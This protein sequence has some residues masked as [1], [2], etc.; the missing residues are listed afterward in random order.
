MEIATL[1]RRQHGVIARAQALV[2]LTPEQVRWRLDSGAWVR[3]HPGVYRSAPVT[4]TWRGRAQ[5]A[6]LYYGPG[7]ALGLE[8]AAYLWG[9]NDVEPAM[10]HVDLPHGSQHVRRPGIR[11]RRRRRLATVNRRGFL[12]AAAAHCVIDLGDAPAAD[13]DDAI[14]VAARAVQ[15]RVV[16]V[17]EL[18]GE[19]AARRT[20]RHRRALELAL[21]VVAQGAESGLEVAFHLGVLRAHGLPPME[22]AVP[23]TAGGGGI[24]RDFLDRD[25]GIVVETDGHLGHDNAQR[26]TDNR[27]DRATAARGGVTLR[28]DWVEVQFTPC[29]V[30][31]DVAGEQ[32]ARGWSGEARSCGPG[33]ALPLARQASA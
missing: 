23:D 24:R 29:A 10:V 5:A 6:L 7:A 20:H 8:S 27:R 31:A 12:V 32:R 22:M 13:R 18:A 2:E 19:L 28:T 1:A 33:C 4:L 17:D 3:V 21:G 15:R 25:R 14:A 16:T 30:A 9:I 11:L 26:R